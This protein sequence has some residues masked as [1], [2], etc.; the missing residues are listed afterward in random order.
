[1]ALTQRFDELKK[2][3]MEFDLAT[4]VAFSG[5]RVCDSEAVRAALAVALPRLVAS[6][7]QTFLTGMAVGFDLLAGEAVLQ[8]KASGIPL[9][10]C[11]VIPYR[12]QP[13]H[14]SA[15]WHTRYNR[16]LAEADEIILLQEEYSQ[17]CLHRRNDFL[18][19]HASHL[20]AWYDGA[21]S[22]GTFYTIRRARSRGIV[23]ENL[24]YEPDLF[25]HLKL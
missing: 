16:L 3:P 19:D 11:A 8:L 15:E 14:F 12:A 25:T 17:G 6:G 13:R 7:F 9:M 10:L 22:G 23:V 20:M 21:K 18:V 2:R 1:M 4:S 24:F 5:H